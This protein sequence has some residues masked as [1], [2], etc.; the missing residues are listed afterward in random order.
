MDYYKLNKSYARDFFGSDEKL[1]ILE[2]DIN[3]DF[4]NGYE[5]CML[6][7][8]SMVAFSSESNYSLDD[9]EEYHWV[10]YE[11]GL[12]ILN[13]SKI[14]S[15]YDD[16]TNINFNI[17]TWGEIRNNS[18]DSKTGNIMKKIKL[19]KNQFRSNYYGYLKLK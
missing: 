12:E 6:I 4:K 10:V 13:G 3:E 18:I 15:D 1:R 5:I 8:G 19:T 14:E 2:K 7:D 16:V 17:F 11:G 9:F